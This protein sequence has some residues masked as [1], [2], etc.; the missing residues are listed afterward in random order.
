[1]RL[2]DETYF[3]DIRKCV[4]LMSSVFGSNHRCEQ[5]FSLMKNVK[6]RTY[7]WTFWRDA[8]ES[9][10]KLNFILKDYLSKRGDKY[11]MT[12]LVKE[13]Y[14]NLFAIVSQVSNIFWVIMT[15]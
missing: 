1:M 14:I 5:L 11:L 15:F 2:Y 4:L 10:Q 8:C 12:D 9:Q 3:P 7:W 6:S 13:N